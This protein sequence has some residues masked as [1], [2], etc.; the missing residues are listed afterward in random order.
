MTSRVSEPERRRRWRLVLGGGEA[1]GTGV[2]LSGADVRI[3][4]ALGAVYDRGTGGRSRGGARTGDLGRSAP[5]VARWLGDIRTYFPTPVV[6]MLQ[7][8]AV[9]RLDLRRLLLEPELLAAAEPDLHLV[10]LLV[11]LGHLLPEETRAT[12]RQ[13]VATVL[14]ELERRFDDRTRAAV[15]GALA[16]A[17]HVRRP[18]PADVDWARTVHANLRHWLPEH[19]TV[20]PEQLIGDARRRP[21]LARDVVVAID[22]SGS[23]ADSVVHASVFA[24]VLARMPALRTT[25]LAFDTT[26]VDLTGLL[27]DPVDVLFGVQLG[28]GTDLAG[29]LAAC[30]RR[31]ERPRDTLV[32][33][34]SDL[35]ESGDPEL[36]LRHAAELVLSGARLLCLLALSD[37]GTPAHD[38]L[39]AQRLAD[40]GATVTACSPDGFPDVL[41]A[42]LA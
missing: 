11:E 21:A 29:A 28:G 24:A 41:A 40:L 34:V 2:G 14:A 31:V 39:V 25:L 6:Q 9:E 26:V 12:A 10:T 7:R 13:V 19:R 32:V 23:M 38:R 18:R 33:L 3:D 27:A 15:R 20:V 8:D 30:R 36:M 42:A 16:R 22:Q 17:A 5:R 1:D 37:D 35:F 4:A